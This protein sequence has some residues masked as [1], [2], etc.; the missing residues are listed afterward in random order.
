MGLTRCKNRGQECVAVFTVGDVIGE[1]VGQN[2]SKG[3]LLKAT[4]IKLPPGPHGFHIHKAGDLRGKGCAGAC[5]HFHKG[6]A[7][8]HG[9]QP[10]SK[11]PRHTGDLGNIELAPTGEFEKT[12]L[13]KGVR[14]SELWGRSIIVHADEDDLGLGGH[15]DS[16]TTGHSGSRIAC[17]I[18]GRVSTPTC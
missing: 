12:Y 5:A 14:I 15:D 18:I 4:F 3:V 9:D 1:V 6:A 7:T 13:L 2:V 11:R 16:H 17:A 10:G 8:N